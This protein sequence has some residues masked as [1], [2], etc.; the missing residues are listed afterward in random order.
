[1]S[2]L[3][4]CSSAIVL[5][6]RFFPLCLPC[7]PAL[8]FCCCF[9]FVLCPLLHPHTKNEIKNI[10]QKSLLTP[11]RVSANHG[12]APPRLTGG[13]RGR[14]SEVETDALMN[15]QGIEPLMTVAEAFSDEL[16][17]L[18]ANEH[19]KGSARDV[20]VMASM[21][22]CGYFWE[23]HLARHSRFRQLEVSFESQ[24]GHS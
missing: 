19:F 22:R 9:P 8:S 5:V 17:T 2:H 3:I 4:S 11:D 18:R 1:M 7:L 15:N 14:D 10:Y 21:M 13:K 6:H 24:P 12:N 16:Q 20:E 23:R